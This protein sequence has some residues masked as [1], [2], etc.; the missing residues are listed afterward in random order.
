MLRVVIEPPPTADPERPTYAGPPR[1]LPPGL[2]TAYFAGGLVLLV[3]GTITAF[4]LAAKIIDRPGTE[5][6][7]RPSGDRSRSAPA[8]RSGPGTAA[9]ASPDPIRNRIGPQ[10]AAMGKTITIV[11]DNDDKFEVTVQTG[12]FRRS[13]CNEYAVHPKHGGY[14]PAK[15]TVKVLSGEPDVGVFNFRFERP[16]GSW[17]D[18]VGGSGCDDSLT[19]L[20]HRMVAGRTYRATAVFDLPAD[21]KGNVIFSYPYLD[22]AAQ[23]KLK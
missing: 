10:R 16:D 4:Y 1:R 8:T 11:G 13:G 5:V 23:W 21:L 15:I 18:T 6:A 19:S 22:V 3:V 14:L 12:K 9:P 7:L 20:M 2:V 17:L